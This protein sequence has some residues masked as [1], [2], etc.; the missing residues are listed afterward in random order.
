MSAQA[1]PAPPSPR[2]PPASRAE[3]HPRAATAPPTSHREHNSPPAVWGHLCNGRLDSTIDAHFV[4]RPVVLVLGYVIRLL[5]LVHFGLKFDVFVYDLVGVWFGFDRIVFR[6]G[7]GELNSCGVG[8][9]ISLTF[10][11]NFGSNYD[12]CGRDISHSYPTIDY[13]ELNLFKYSM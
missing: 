8:F 4:Q 13:V 3:D 10:R 9:D 11:A 6:F 5:S 7:S 1:G 12:L 2:G